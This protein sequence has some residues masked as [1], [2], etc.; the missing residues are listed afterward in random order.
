MQST[1]VI[2]PAVRIVVAYY[3]S[4]NEAPVPQ[5]QAADLVEAQFA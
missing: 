5:V 3:G 4:E 1:G 2:T